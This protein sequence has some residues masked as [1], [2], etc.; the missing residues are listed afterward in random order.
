[1][2]QSDLPKPLLLTASIFF[3]TI[4]LGRFIDWIISTSHLN[5]G[6]RIL[7]WPRLNKTN[8]YSQKFCRSAHRAQLSPE[9]MH[10]T[11][12]RVAVGKRLTEQPLM[13]NVLA[14]LAIESEAATAL[15]M[16]LARAFDA[17]TDEAETEH[18]LLL[19]TDHDRKPP[20]I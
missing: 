5:Q 11:R 12:H 14:D 19:R 3:S 9:P 15:A 2:A 20:A 6:K 10:H 16:R 17:Q 7:L 4:A 8:P 1:M 18:Q 13:K